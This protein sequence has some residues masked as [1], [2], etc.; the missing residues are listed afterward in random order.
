MDW[1]A[2][3]VEAGRIAQVWTAEG[4][5][6]GA[7][8]LFDADSLRAEA[9][10][11]LANLELSLPFRADTVVRY[12]SISKHF[13]AALLLR[14]GGLAQCEGMPGLDD[15]LGTYLPL[16]PALGAVTVGRA[17]DMTSGLPD[18]METLWLLGVPPSATQ[19]HQAL[20]AFVQRLDGLN[21][22]SGSEISYSN[23][24][25]RLVQAALEAKGIDYAA[26]LR[27]R[28]LRPLGLGIR[29][30]YD[31]AEP[32]PD[33]AGG[34]WKS[35]AGWRRGRYGLHI[36]ASGGLAGS[37]H[38]LVTWLQA[39]MGGRAPLAGL[40][41]KLARLRA[42]ADGR[43]TAYGL[44][45]ARQAL[46]A[47]VLVGHGGS[48]PGFKNHFLLDP[49]ARAGVV[50]V[51]NREDTD[52]AGAALRV[53]AALHGIA[54]PSP[55]RGV[56]PQ[57]LYA[58]PGTPFWLEHAGG[59][60]TWLG[61]QESVYPDGEGGVVGR[62]AHLPLR[63]RVE[64]GA[65]V[66]EVG[67]VGRRFVPVP[68]GIAPEAGWAGAWVCAAQHAAFEVAVAEGEAR[69]IVGAG[70]LLAELALH[71]IGEGRALA[72]RTEGPWTQRACL[73]F[74]RDEVR[75]VTNR[76]RVLRFVRR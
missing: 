16:S 1:Q 63:L 12:A 57:G 51:S 35:P 15:F 20:L 31:E 61:A 58:M 39:L 38:D 70:P 13:L 49:E 11:G 36:S 75:L 67:L 73:Q 19:G 76:S 34:Y 29:L 44:G 41:P 21:F 50:V 60:V 3:A 14:E 43:T 30:P 7:V 9:C 24:G 45:L 37:A 62:S 53:M 6:G 2:A 69:L 48:L 27:E 10:G 22:A 4:G 59:V 71:P 65:I 54:L 46:G 32:V 72:E 47:R 42:L 17:L 23:T 28:F 26:E 18:A 64:G 74:G 52:A 68:G 25:Y 5:P 33:L 55:A 66:G 56:L 8:L 40:F